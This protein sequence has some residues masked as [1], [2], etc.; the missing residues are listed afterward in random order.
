MPGEQTLRRRKCG[1]LQLFEI[2]QLGGQ[3]YRNDGFTCGFVESRVSDLDGEF[4]K[5]ALIVAAFQ[6]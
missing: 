6:T 1:A 3:S 5:A 4:R 2:C